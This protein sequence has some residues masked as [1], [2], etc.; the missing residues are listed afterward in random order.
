MPSFVWLLK[1]HMHIIS[2]QNLFIQKFS[3]LCRKTV[4]S[5]NIFMWLEAVTTQGSFISLKDKGAAQN[6][7]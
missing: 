6:V 1:K 5:Y 7:S 2:K 4:L 3:L